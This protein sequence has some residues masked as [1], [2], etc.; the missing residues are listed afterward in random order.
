MPILQ[1]RN[2]VLKKDGVCS[3]STHV[4]HRYSVHA[5]MPSEY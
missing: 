2:R 5:I 4:L 1:W 3:E